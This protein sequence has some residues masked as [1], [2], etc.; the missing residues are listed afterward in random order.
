V[1]ASSIDPSMLRKRADWMPKLA[2]YNAARNTSGYRRGL[3]E[4]EI[5]RAIRQRLFNKGGKGVFF[6]FDPVIKN[7]EKKKMENVGGRMKKK[8]VVPLFGDTR[9]KTRTIESCLR[10]R[11]GRASVEVKKSGIDQNDQKKTKRIEHRRHSQN[12]GTGKK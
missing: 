12:Q 9:E 3:L 6:G 5:C 8:R 1:Y 7:G 10:K 2:S 4:Q 11:G